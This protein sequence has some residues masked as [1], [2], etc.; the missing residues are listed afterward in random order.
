ML[1]YY[2]SPQSCVYPVYL[3]IC[4]LHFLNCVEWTMSPA[5]HHGESHSAIRALT[6]TNESIN[7]GFGSLFS[8]SVSVPCMHF[9]QAEFNIIIYIPFVSPPRFA[10]N[11]IARDAMHYF[12]PA[13]EPTNQQTVSIYLSSYQLAFNQVSEASY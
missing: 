10:L 7:V 6:P 9:R 3:R 11:L 13:I 4:W 2:F 5:F 8:C 12:Q 1:T